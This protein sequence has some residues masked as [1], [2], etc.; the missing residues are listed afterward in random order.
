L[1]KIIIHW[2]LKC[3]PAYKISYTGMKNVNYFVYFYDLCMKLHALAQNYLHTYVDIQRWKLLLRKIF[4]S[5]REDFVH[6][7]ET[8]LYTLKSWLRNLKY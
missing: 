1:R 7:N 8:T 3:L 5:G 2:V 6:R 4:K